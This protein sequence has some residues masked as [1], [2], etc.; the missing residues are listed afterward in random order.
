M[1]N[2]LLTLTN[3]PLTKYKGGGVYPNLFDAHPPFQIDGNFGAASGIAEML[4]QSHRRDAAGNLV[5]DLLPALPGAWPDGS[6]TGL[7]ARGA[8]EVSMTWRDGRLVAAEIKSLVGNPLR[9][10]YGKSMIER[11]SRPGEVIR[12]DGRLQ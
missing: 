11:Q 8:F 12:L 6:V 7:R 2:N 10:R 3:S 4:V 5:L 9:V 1:L